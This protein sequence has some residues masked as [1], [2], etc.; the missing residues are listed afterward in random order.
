[1]LIAEDNNIN[2]RVA[3]LSL[4]RLGYRADVAANGLEVIE[5]LTSFTYDIIF[6]D[7]H[8]PELDG[9]ETTRQI[10][11]NESIKQPYIAALTANATVQD[12]EECRQAGMDD[13]LSK[14]FRLRDLRKVLARFQATL[15]EPR[16]TGDTPTSTPNEGPTDRHNT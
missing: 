4:E 6:M 2:Q 14:P 10:R 9:L 12:H 11:A 7:V 15:T 8:M 3:R 1:V 5:L 13:F 16:S